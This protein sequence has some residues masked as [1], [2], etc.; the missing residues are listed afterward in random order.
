MTRRSPIPPS[1][2]AGLVLA[3]GL[4]T[5]IQILW[6]MAVVGIPPGASAAETARGALSN[7]YF[8]A[9]MLAF[10]A[11][12]LNWMRVLS[13]ADLSFAQPFT[14]LST[15]TVLAVSVLSL[16]ERLSLFKIVGV[17]LVLL[18]VYFISRTPHRTG[19]AAG[20]RP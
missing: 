16:H 14:A 18:G 19:N 2:V 1:V 12:L 8:Y 5:A 17:G 20:D 11:Q 9:A 15:I 7:P 4:D 6:K 3:I 10:A 13:R